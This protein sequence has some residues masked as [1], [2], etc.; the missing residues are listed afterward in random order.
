[1]RFDVQDNRTTTDRALDWL[2]SEVAPVYV[3]VIIALMILWGA[4]SC[5]GA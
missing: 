3:G 5:L 4:A 2:I 1:M